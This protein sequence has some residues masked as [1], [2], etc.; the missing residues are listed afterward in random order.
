MNIGDKRNESI[1]IERNRSVESGKCSVVGAGSFF[2][3]E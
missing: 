3:S 2:A 1:L